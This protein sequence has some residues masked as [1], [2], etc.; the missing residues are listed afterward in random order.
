M[1][2]FLVKKNNLSLHRL[3]PHCCK[4]VRRTHIDRPSRTHDPRP[5]HPAQFVLF[6]RAWPGYERSVCWNGRLSSLCAHSYVCRPGA[7]SGIPG[8]YGLYSF[9]LRYGCF[10]R[11]RGI[12]Y[13]WTTNLEREL[14]AFVSFRVPTTSTSFSKWHTC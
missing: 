2:A 7:I 4:S 9:L 12:D 8:S 14:L 6:S 11:S 1:S 10:G 5:A 3:Y 13:I